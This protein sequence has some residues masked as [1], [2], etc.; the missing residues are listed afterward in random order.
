MSLFQSKYRQ[1]DL[2]FTDKLSVSGDQGLTR[3]KARDKSKQR[4]ARQRR[5]PSVAR[6]IALELSWPGNISRSRKDS[7]ESSF[8]TGHDFNSLP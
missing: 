6:A 5:E 8:V 4:P 1:S 2:A 7:V 3:L